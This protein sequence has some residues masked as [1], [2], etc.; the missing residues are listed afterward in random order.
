M[1][2]DDVVSPVP[3]RRRTRR[4]WPTGATTLLAIAALVAAWAVLVLRG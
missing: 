1:D 3:A 2:A 4:P